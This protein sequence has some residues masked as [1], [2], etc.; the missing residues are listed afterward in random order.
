MTHLDDLIVE[1]ALTFLFKQIDSEL[2]AKS[3]KYFVHYCL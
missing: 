1:F 2:F 3:L